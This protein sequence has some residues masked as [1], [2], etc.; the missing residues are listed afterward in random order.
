M[1]ADAAREITSRVSHATTVSRSPDPIPG[2]KTHH[3]AAD[4]TEP[5]DFIEK[6]EPAVVARGKF[7]LA[8]VWMHG[9]GEGVWPKLHEV[10]APR[11]RVFEVLGSSDVS[12]LAE[13]ADHAYLVP[14]ALHR[15]VV[16]GKVDE[17]GTTRWLTHKEIS[18]GTARLVLRDRS[19]VIGRV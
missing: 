9:S 5:A 7:D 6:I 18:R 19:G 17:N 12:E 1:L 3:V 10:L 11:T 4:W 13:L 8:V 15:R 2:T 14:D 16:L